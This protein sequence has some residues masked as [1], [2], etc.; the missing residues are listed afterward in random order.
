MQFIVPNPSATDDDDFSDEFTD[1]DY[2]V[3]DDDID[4]TCMVATIDTPPPTIVPPNRHSLRIREA[5]AHFK[6]DG[7]MAADD[8]Y[9]TPDDDCLDATTAPGS[10]AVR[11]AILR[12]AVFSAGTE[13]R[14]W[15]EQ[16][17]YPVH[18]GRH[19]RFTGYRLFQDDLTVSLAIADL[20]RGHLTSDDIQI[21]LMDLI[22]RLGWSPGTHSRERLTSSLLCL[23][24]ARFE[25][26]SFD[27]SV[28]KFRL[29]DALRIGGDCIEGKLSGGFTRFQDEPGRGTFVPLERRKALREGLQTWLAG[30]V[31]ATRCNEP[32]AL[33]ALYD[34]SG[35]MQRHLGEFGREVRR[36]LDR[37]QSVGF[38]THWTQRPGGELTRNSFTISKPKFIR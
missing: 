22:H 10:T 13:V 14:V 6:A 24:N 1:A 17:V 37:L 30:W 25:V 9:W 19:F 4:D 32:V 15:Q 18:F 29:F 26:T 28:T 21:D 8:E 5:L 16:V 35:T 2:P 3:P 33:Q 12:S 20:L 36:A 38:V 23:A 11:S 7:Y 27:F 31:L 34:H